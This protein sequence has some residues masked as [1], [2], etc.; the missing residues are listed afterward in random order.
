MALLTVAATL[1]SVVPGLLRFLGG[2]HSEDAATRIVHTAAEVLGVAPDEVEQALASNPEALAQVKTRMIELEAELARE[3]TE[4]FR[5][6]SK[7]Y[8][9][10]G[11]SSDKYLRRW[12]PTFGYGMT[13]AFVYQ[14]LV[15]TTV[16]AWAVVMQPERA[17]EIIKQLGAVI[18]GFGVM[19]GFALSVLG[20]YV[21]GR[22][23][24]KGAPGILG[25]LGNL[26]R[27]RK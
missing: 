3:E 5:I 17:S 16:A 19:W 15:F 8:R 4:R 6:S 20:V 26:I 27:R 13:V 22:T 14:V 24:E 21:N 23:Q 2:H 18:A 1:A 10:D 25:T 11:A 9:A 7:N 12:R